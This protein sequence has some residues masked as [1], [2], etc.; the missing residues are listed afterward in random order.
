MFILSNF[1]AG[2]GY[3]PIHKVVLFHGL[4]FFPDAVH[5]KVFA[6]MGLHPKNEKSY[7]NFL[8]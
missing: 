6:Y 2:K 5:V 7:R 3:P 1:G 8:S 4:F